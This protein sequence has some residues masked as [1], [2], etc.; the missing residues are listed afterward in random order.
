MKGKTHVIVLGLGLLNWAG[1]QR[2]QLGLVLRGGGGSVVLWGGGGSSHRGVVLSST[3]T[4]AA[5]EVLG[6]GSLG[7]GL[8]LVAGSSGLLDTQVRLGL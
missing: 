1:G 8:G 3:Q 4:H 6:T 2:P 5:G 7:G